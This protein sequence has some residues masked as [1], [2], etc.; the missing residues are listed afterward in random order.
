[1]ALLINAGQ[2]KATPLLAW[3]P[4]DLTLLLGVAVAAWASLLLFTRPT[5]LNSSAP[6][7]V[8]LLAF[9]VASFD[10]PGSDYG[11]TKVLTLFTVTAV[12][13]LSPFVLFRERSHLDYFFSATL[14]IASIA[15]VLTITNPASVADYSTRVTFDGTNT[16][17]AARVLGA[18]IVVCVIRAVWST[19]T[20]RRRLTYGALTPVLLWGLLSTGSR[21][22][23]IATALAVLAVCAV[24]LATRRSNGWMIAVLTAV[25][26]GGAA[27]AERA[28][29][30]GTSR[31][32]GFFEGT[33][34][35]ST[36][37]R[38]E[39]WRGTAEA[40]P[41]HPLGVGVGSFS[42][43]QVLWG[44]YTYPHNVILEVFAEA[45][46]TTGILLCL[47]V[48]IGTVRSIR[49]ANVAGDFLTLGLLV[50]A[51]V[52]AMVSGDINSNRLVWVMLA[53]AMMGP[54][55]GHLRAQAPESR[56]GGART[57]RHPPV[58]HRGA[59]PSI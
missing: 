45:G 5:R 33:R 4:V 51:L 43:T 58:V 9:S 30:D 23:F 2:L 59:N 15:A 37:A 40:I 29:T 49:G 10:A 46:W 28:S 57:Q 21:G 31:I 11:R 16:I 19:T 12:L 22:P 39:L 48:A 36:R 6:F 35:T 8:L 27:I 50:F 42:D 47:I 54:R 41:D 13:M 18:G 53:I 17:G 34:D 38:N 3:V 56:L 20:V 25:I 7:F 44:T 14:G 55:G 24:A 32:F 1:M 26:F 52:N